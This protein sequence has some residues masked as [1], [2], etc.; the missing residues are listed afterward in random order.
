MCKYPP[1]TL[2][3]GQRIPEDG[4]VVAAQV[5]RV[6]DRVEYWPPNEFDAVLLDNLPLVILVIHVNIGAGVMLDLENIL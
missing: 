2:V 1:L 5:P 3:F 4:N 6:T